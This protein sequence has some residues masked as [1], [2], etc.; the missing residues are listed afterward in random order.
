MYYSK[1]ECYNDTILSLRLGIIV[2]EDL[3]DLLSYYKEGEHYECCSGLVKAYADFKQEKKQII[4][5]RRDFKG[6]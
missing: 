2:E 4:D 1:E 5:E 6:S 3:K